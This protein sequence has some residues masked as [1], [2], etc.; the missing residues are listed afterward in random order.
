MLLGRTVILNC[1][2]V[3]CRK[4]PAGEDGQGSRNRDCPEVNINQEGLTAH[5]VGRKSV[6]SLDGR[7]VGI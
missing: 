4:E 6:W 2:S 3:K 5:T 7:V 1:G